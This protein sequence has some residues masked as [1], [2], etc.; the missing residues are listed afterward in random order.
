MYRFY[1]NLF[2]WTQTLAKCLTTAWTTLS[3]DCLFQKKENFWFNIFVVF[4]NYSLCKIICCLNFARSGNLFLYQFRVNFAELWYELLHTVGVTG[5]QRMLTPRNLILFEFVILF[6]IFEM[7]DSSLSFC[8]LKWSYRASTCLTIGLPEPMCYN[9]STSTFKHPLLRY[10]LIKD[11][12]TE[13]RPHPV[14]Q[15]NC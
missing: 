9:L 10:N 8:L 1:T 14:V 11:K 7:V 4:R 12:S 13:H 15:R 3:K 2:T 6:W 5:Q